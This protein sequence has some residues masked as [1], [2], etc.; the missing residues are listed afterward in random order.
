MHL[1]TFLL[2]LRDSLFNVQGCRKQENQ[3]LLDSIQNLN[4][5][6]VFFK[7]NC[8]FDKK[9]VLILLAHKFDLTIC[10]FLILKSAETPTFLFFSVFMQSAM[11]K[12]IYFKIYLLKFSKFQKESM[13]S[14]FLSKCEPK[15]VRISDL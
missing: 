13:K 10:I 9:F 8:N 1:K 2:K 14:S 6:L 12:A 7:Q 15:I 4:R 5:R 3:D 11:T